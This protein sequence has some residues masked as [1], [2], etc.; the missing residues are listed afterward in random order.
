MSEYVLKTILVKIKTEDLIKTI[1]V[2]SIKT[3]RKETGSRGVSP[4]HVSD[5]V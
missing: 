2:A 1:R 4:G 5:D 3:G